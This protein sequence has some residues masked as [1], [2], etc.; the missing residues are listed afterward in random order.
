MNEDVF[1]ILFVCM[2][3]I[4]FSGEK[5]CILVAELIVLASGANGLLV[6]ELNL[7]VSLDTDASQVGDENSC[8]VVT[9][10]MV[11]ASGAKGLLVGELNLAAS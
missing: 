7:A 8:F 3:L 11:L 10:L 4:A 6:G 5:R 1:T 2:V 9:A